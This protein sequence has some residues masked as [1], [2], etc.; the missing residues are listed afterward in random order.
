MFAF[1][2]INENNARAIASWR[3]EPPYDLY[4]YLEEETN[5]LQHILHPQNNFYSIVDE[6]SELVAYCSFGQDGQVT[7]GNYCDRARSTFFS[8]TSWV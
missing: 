7:G 2:Q 1:H 4:N 5:L 6:N 8:K 3:Y